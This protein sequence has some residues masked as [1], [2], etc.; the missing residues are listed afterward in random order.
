MGLISARKHELDFLI[1]SSQLKKCPP[2]PSSLPQLPWLIF[3]ISLTCSAYLYPPQQ[4]CAMAPWP[5]FR[6]RSAFWGGVGGGRD[7][8]PWRTMCPCAGAVNQRDLHHFWPCSG[9]RRISEFKTFNGGKE[10]FG[11]GASFPP[12]T[13]VVEA[14]STAKS[15]KL[16]IPIRLAHGW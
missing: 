5:C 2:P 6:Y 4:P 13:Y 15:C 14:R 3:I 16:K 8:T 11:E 7:V 9:V 12:F 10:L 1:F